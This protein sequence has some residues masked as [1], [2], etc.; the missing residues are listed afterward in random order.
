MEGYFYPG[1]RSPPLLR[2]CQV[3]R[4]FTMPLKTFCNAF[5]DIFKCLCLGLPPRGL[6]PARSRR[7]PA[8]AGRRRFVV[9]PL[10]LARTSPRR[11]P[12]GALRQEPQDLANSRRRGVLEDTKTARREAKTRRPGPEGNWVFFCPFFPT[13]TRA[14]RRQIKTRRPAVILCTA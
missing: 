5:K 12:L 14:S 8:L 10:C 11:Y 6:N 9:S 3:Q 7:Q 4:Q 2:F 1:S 13:D